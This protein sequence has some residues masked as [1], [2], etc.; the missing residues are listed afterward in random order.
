MAAPPTTRAGDLL[1]R[2]DQ[3]TGTS[4]V[5]EIEA[6]RTLSDD[7]RWIARLFLWSFVLA[8]FVVLIATFA[9]ALTQ[10]TTW[11]EPAQALL[12]I[13]AQVLLPVVTL[14]IGFYFRS[15]AR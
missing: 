4:A 2:L 15:E 6:D 10:P 1:A 3:A 13:V 11:K 8:V 7:R 12:A 9:L 5:V 14:V